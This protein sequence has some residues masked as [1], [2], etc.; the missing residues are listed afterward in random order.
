MT[1]YH[2]ALYCEYFACMYWIRTCVLPSLLSLYLQGNEHSSFCSKLIVRLNFNK[3]FLIFLATLWHFFARTNT[4][5]KW[6]RPLRVQCEQVSIHSHSQ[7]LLLAPPVSSPITIYTIIS[8]VFL[9]HNICVQ[10]HGKSGGLQLDRRWKV[11]QVI[12]HSLFR[13][14]YEEK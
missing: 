9:F 8:I 1:G 2:Y 5:R 6:M 14:D 3:N 4:V 13:S 7:F 12:F 10:Y 11:L